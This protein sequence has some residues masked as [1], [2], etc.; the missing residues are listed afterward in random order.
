MYKG[1]DKSFAH[2]HEKE[3]KYQDLMVQNQ[4]FI[5][6]EHQEEILGECNW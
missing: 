4:Q 1:H 3:V 5:A 2:I 6:K